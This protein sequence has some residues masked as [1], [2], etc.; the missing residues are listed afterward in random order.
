MGWAVASPQHKG[1]NEASVIFLK[2]IFIIRL[3]VVVYPWEHWNFWRSNFFSCVPLLMPPP[4]GTWYFYQDTIFS[5]L[6]IF[7]Y[8]HY[9]HCICQFFFFTFQ[10]FYVATSRQLK[11][12]ESISRS[13]IFSHFG[14]TVQGASTIRAYGQQER[15]ILESEARV[16]ENII[17]YYPGL[18]SNR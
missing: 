15:F 4:S 16:D 14:E 5:Y 18:A 10:R 13:P 12:L 1:D 9:L 2:Y 6:I 17:C 8:I 3:Q 11:R 7:L